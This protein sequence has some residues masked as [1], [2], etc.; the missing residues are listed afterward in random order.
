MNTVD[1]TERMPPP[2]PDGFGGGVTRACLVVAGSL[3]VLL[4]DQSPNNATATR[5]QKIGFFI[6]II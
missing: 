4:N 2:P 6:T 1:V 5:A 3:S